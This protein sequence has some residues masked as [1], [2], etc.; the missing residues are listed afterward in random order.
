MDIHVPPAPIEV[1][2]EENLLTPTV[3][4]ILL[5]NLRHN[6]GVLQRRAGHAEVMGVIKADAYGHG[7]IPIARTL[8]EEGIRR[9]AVATAAEA[10]RLRQAGIEEP[11]LVF[12]APLPEFL[13]WY[14]KYELDIT[15]P[16]LDVARAVT[17]TARK[18]GPLRVHVKVDTGMGRIG[19]PPEETAEVIRL[20]ENA[21]G[22][23]I[24]GLWTHFALADEE[25]ETFTAEQLERFAQVVRE[26]GDAAEFIHTANSPAL[27]RYRG[28]FEPFDRALVRT[29]IALYGLANLQRL[30]DEPGLKPVM[31]F[32][33]RVTHVK[34]VPPGTGISYAHTWRAPGRRRIA[35]ISAGYADGYPRLASNRSTVGIDESLYP[36]AGNV[37]MDM[38]MVDLGEPDGPGASVQVGDEAVLF[39]P[40]GPSALQMAQWA[41]TIPYEICCRVSA[42]VPRIYAD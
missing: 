33:S 4:E 22:V 35:T 32:K 1:A 7:A 42:R 17:E 14:P 5:P 10:V 36:Q 12:A 29:G 23:T 41:Q 3:A 28:S 21:P 27:L 6:A 19:I 9:F 8:R 30:I 31:R 25:N 13:P 16:S 18:T 20:L 37:C 11:I 24:T 2:Q 38:F 39:G 40:G 34:T 26:F 15:V